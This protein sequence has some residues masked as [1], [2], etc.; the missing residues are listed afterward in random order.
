MKQ[1]TKS[2]LRLP[3]ATGPVPEETP[4]QPAEE[5]LRESEARLRALIDNLPFEFWAM[6]HTSRHGQHGAGQFNF[7]CLEIYS[8]AFASG[9]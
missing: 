6:D 9:N 8:P 7:E 3:K 1:Q 4:S 5:A 2:P